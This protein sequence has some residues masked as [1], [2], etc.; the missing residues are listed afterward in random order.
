LQ[1]AA[2]IRDAR[3]RPPRSRSQQPRGSLAVAAKK[4]EKE[5]DV[6]HVDRDQEGYK[7]LQ[8]HEM[9]NNNHH[10]HNHDNIH[11]LAIVTKREEKENDDQH[12]DCD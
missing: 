8:A 4:E 11:S 12:E 1:I 6:Q 7:Q 5:N 2:S 9:Q 3:L 10:D